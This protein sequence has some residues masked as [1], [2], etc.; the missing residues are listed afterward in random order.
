MIDDSTCNIR[1]YPPPSPRMDRC[2]LLSCDQPHGAGCDSQVHI[3]HHPLCFAQ[4]L[5]E[6]L[7]LKV[8]QVVFVSQLELVISL[9]TCSCLLHFCNCNLLLDLVLEFVCPQHSHNCLH[10]LYHHHNQLL[11]LVVVFHILLSHLLLV[12]LI[13]YF[14]IL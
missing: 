2:C 10:N 3:L 5:V 12:L 8:G 1:R 13:Y 7:L 11:E 6:E 14:R 4:S 9:C